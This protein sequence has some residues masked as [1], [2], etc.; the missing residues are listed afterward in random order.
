LK[1]VRKNKTAVLLIVALLGLSSIPIAVHPARAAAVAAPGY[2]VSDFATGFPSSPECGVPGCGPLGVAFDASGNLFVSDW[3]NG[4]LYKFPLSGGDASTHLV[5]IIPGNVSGLVFAKDGTLLGGRSLD[6]DIVKL[7]LPG[8]TVGPTIAKL[9]TTAYGGIGLAIDPLTG[10]LFTD[11]CGVGGIFRVSIVT[12]PPGTLTSYSMVFQ[13]DGIGFDN[14]GVL[15]AAARQCGGGGV[16]QIAGTNSANPGAFTCLATV[17][18]I[19]GLAVS[20]KSGAPII[21]GNRNDGIIT[22]LDLSANQPPAV[23]DTTDIVSGGTRGDFATVGPDGCLYATQSAS[24]IRVTKP[25]GECPLSGFHDLSDPNPL[26]CRAPCSSQPRVAT[27]GGNVYAAWLNNTSGNSNLLFSSSNNNGSSFGPVIKITNST[28]GKATNPQI[29]A[30]GSDV[31]VVWQQ[32]VSLTNDHIFLRKST[33]NGT[34]FGPVLALTGGS[35]SISTSRFPEVAAVGINVDIVWLGC[36]DPNCDTLGGNLVE[37]LFSTTSGGT[38]TLSTT[39]YGST[40]PQVDATASDIFAT[41]GDISSG[42]AQTFFAV[43][44]NGGTSFGTFSLGST[45]SGET[46]LH[47]EMAVAGNSV[48][49]TWTNQTSSSDNTMFAASNN[50][51]GSFAAALNL[52]KA[53]VNDLNPEVAASGTN[54]YDTWSEAS[55]GNTEVLYRASANNGASFG[56]LLN[57]SNVP[58][59]SNETTIAASGSNVHVAWI[60]SGTLNN[61]VYFASSS[62][63]GSTFAAPFNLISDSLSS[64]PLVAGSGSYAFVGWLDETTGNGDIYLVSGKPF[65]FDFSVANSGTISLTQGSSGSNSVNLAPTGGTSQFVYLSCGSGLP[66]GASCSFNPASGTPGFSSGLTISTQVSTPTGSYSITVTGTAGDLGFARA[67]STQV[68][69]IVNPAPFDFSLSA[70]G[71]ITDVQGGFG[72][73]TITTTIVS[74][75]SQSVSLS[76]TG[77]LPSGA[78]CSFNPISGFPSFSS[79]LTITTLSSTPQGSYTITVTGT[80]GGVTHATSFVLTVN[81]PTTV[82]GDF[83]PV[84]KF[85][86]LAPYTAFASVI[87]AASF[88]AILLVKQVGRR[89]KGP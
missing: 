2:V 55:G 60:E 12:N 28:T 14:N 18:T 64:N 25:G 70:S 15:Y 22:R 32:N 26:S 86:L 82:G 45:P 17:P 42:R 9:P 44:A 88:I 78:S 50:N 5:N 59:T 69:L 65:A 27:V 56:N 7:I 47:Q 19:D 79:T 68:T 21:Y 57:L 89:K 39:A 40:E 72:S 83:V 13:P 51:G 54:V 34:T 38:V 53:V 85:G 33:N 48:F 41:W 6:D 87:L 29:A 37:I 52:N 43:S 35:P 49:L 23:T 73:N 67:R 58:G 81:S 30:T 74:G 11:C 3:V 71:G 75:S 63:S 66:S 24:V 84:D 10:D 76:C 61:G 36:T 80:D 4:G 46:D 62:D 1:K 20:P 16:A 8:G 77:G 31:D